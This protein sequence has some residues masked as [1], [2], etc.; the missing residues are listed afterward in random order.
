MSSFSVTPCACGWPSAVFNIFLYFYTNG[1]KEQE[2]E[3]EH[4]FQSNQIKITCDMILLSKT[5]GQNN[6]RF[7]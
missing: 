6:F 7:L 3:Q 1:A 5:T 4:L 2:Q